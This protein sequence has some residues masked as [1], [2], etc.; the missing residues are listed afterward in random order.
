MEGGGRNTCESILIVHRQRWG[1]KVWLD[2]VRDHRHV[3]RVG[4]VHLS[5]R[6]IDQREGKITL[7]DACECE[8]RGREST[9]IGAG[10]G[11]GAAAVVAAAHPAEFPWRP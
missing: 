5:K 7:L 9:C 1:L 3:V 6:L 10:V 8:W 4:C 2:V 11:E